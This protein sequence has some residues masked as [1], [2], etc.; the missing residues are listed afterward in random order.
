MADCD[1]EFVWNH[2]LEGH[3]SVTIR[4]NCSVACCPI[5]VVY[6]RHVPLS[7]HDDDD[8][9]NK[10]NRHKNR[11]LL[12]FASLK[13]ESTLINRITGSRINRN[14]AQNMQ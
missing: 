8:V 11:S 2:C 4:I 6:L 7:D 12:I 1:E 10:L 5:N 9:A 3:L 14:L 13:N